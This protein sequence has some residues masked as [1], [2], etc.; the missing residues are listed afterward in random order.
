MQRLCGSKAVLKR[1]FASITVALM[2]IWVCTGGVAIQRVERFDSIR[3]WGLNDQEGF[4]ASLVG[5]P[6]DFTIP[7]VIVR[8][9][10]VPPFSFTL[11]YYSNGEKFWQQLII[12]SIA[13]QWGRG[14]PVILLT[15]A[16]PIVLT[17]EPISYFNSSSK[18]IVGN[19]RHMAEYTGPHQLTLPSQSGGIVRCQIEAELIGDGVSKKMKITL[20]LAGSTINYTKTYWNYLAER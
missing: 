16:R 15:D 2:S 1:L 3:E 5:V 12:Y 6:S 4:R 9:S 20:D 11:T 17:I 8:H 14:T 7:F 13:V 19:T 18:G 10:E